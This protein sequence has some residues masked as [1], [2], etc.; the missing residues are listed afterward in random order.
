MDA[1]PAPRWGQVDTVLLDLD[2]TLLDL[3]FDNRFWRELVPQRLAER[4]GT[5]F[6]GAWRELVP[7]FEATHGTLDWYCLEYWSREL[8]LDLATL[9]RA[10]RHE[11]AWLPRARSFLER[12]RS[13]GRRIVLVTN[14]H[15]HTLEIKDA[16]LNLRRRFDAVYSSHELG[17]AKEHADFWSRLAGAETDVGERALLVDDSLPVLGAARRHGIGQLWAVR[18]PD[19]REPC[20]AV[21][22]FPSVESVHELALGLADLPGAAQG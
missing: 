15:P 16:Q 3:A 18:R 14:S 13:S 10:V 4:R 2:G 21:D 9:K 20:R 1:N 11:I 6:A 8:D 19:S 5:D 12:L 22:G 17:A 7:M